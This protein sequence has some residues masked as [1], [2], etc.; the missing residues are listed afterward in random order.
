MQSPQLGKPEEWS[1]GAVVHHTSSGD[2]KLDPVRSMARLVGAI[3][4][5]PESTPL[6]T[7]TDNGKT[8]KRIQAK[9]IIGA[10]RNAAAAD[11][12]VAA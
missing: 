11:N 2:T 12:L 9:D 3:Q 10:W 7:Y 6:G 4:T 5:L 1:Q 8:W